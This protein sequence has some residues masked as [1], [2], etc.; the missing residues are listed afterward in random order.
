MGQRAISSTH[1][2]NGNQMQEN[3]CGKGGLVKK[4]LM[5]TS[6]VSAADEAKNQI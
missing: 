2:K 6:E 3:S 1:E 5:N 4:N